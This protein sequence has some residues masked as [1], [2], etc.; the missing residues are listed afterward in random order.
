MGKVRGIIYGTEQSNK[1]R[2]V[3]DQQRVWMLARPDRFPPPQPWSK[4]KPIQPEPTSRGGVLKRLPAETLTLL[5]KTILY[6]PETPHTKGKILLAMA[7]SSKWLRYHVATASGLWIQLC[8]QSEYLPHATGR[9]ETPSADDVDRAI[10]H[11]WRGLYQ[12]NHLQISS[13][14]TMLSTTGWRTMHR[15]LGFRQC[16]I[17][18]G[19]WVLSTKFTKDSDLSS[20]GKILAIGC[21]IAATQTSGGNE[22]APCPFNIDL[23]ESFPELLYRW[24]AEVDPLLLVHR[25]T[26]SCYP[27][28][29][30]RSFAKLVNAC[31]CLSMSA[32][33][34]PSIVSM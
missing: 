18:N 5:L 16:G 29:I 33:M 15:P 4:G 30:L 12:A 3:F 20:E 19:F 34:V 8:A 1:H 24:Q 23:P 7:A 10:H 27:S 32:C 11:D 22:P 28:V 17:V 6:G 31:Y 21:S 26:F 13:L 25:K 9:D 2:F 14:P